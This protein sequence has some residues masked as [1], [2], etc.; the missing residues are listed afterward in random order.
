MITLRKLN[1]NQDCLNLFK[2]IKKNGADVFPNQVDFINFDEFQRWLTDQMVGFYHDLYIF[3]ESNTANYVIGFALA[4]DYRVY[5]GHC[6]LCVCVSKEIDSN[7]LGSFIE[8][9]FKEYPLNKVFWKVVA[10][11]ERILNLACA[12]GF[13]KEMVLKD[14]CYKNGKYQDLWVLSFYSS[15]Q[16]N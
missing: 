3:E 2:F 1:P 14:Y 12:L 5:D 7:M 9:L 11:D 4:Y 15:V 13:T 10:T 16:R 6:Q 8:M